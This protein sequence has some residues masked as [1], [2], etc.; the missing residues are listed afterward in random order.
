MFDAVFFDFDGVVLD[1]ANIKTEAFPKL[2]LKYGDDIAEKVRQYQLIHGG[3]PRKEKFK[4]WHSEHLGVELDEKGLDELSEQFTELVLE[5][6]MK[7]GF[8]GDVINT[9]EILKLKNIPSYVV[10][11]TP[12][13]ELRKI[14]K[15]RG[16]ENYFVELFGSDKKKY[17]IVDDLINKN[18]FRRNK[19]LFIGDA[20]T[21]LEAATKNGTKFLG[22]V[23][24]G[25]KSIF[26]EGIITSSKVDIFN[27]FKEEDLKVVALLPMKKNSER[28]INKNFK[29][30]N[31]K[32]LYWWTLT[33]IS[34]SRYVDKIII[35]TDFDELESMIDFKEFPKVSINKR[36]NSLIGDFV[37]MNKI[38]AFDIEN[39]NAECFIQTHTTNPLV[40]SETFDKAIE[41]FFVK[42]YT[43]DSIFGVTKYQSRFFG[44]S[45]EPINHKKNELLR[46]QDLPPI[47]E[48]N[49]NL[50]I[51]TKDSFSKT[52]S[53][54]GENPCL[55]EIN[56]LESI[57]IDDRE[58]FVLAELICKNLIS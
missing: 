4:V 14:V 45:G 38:I 8:V 57:D 24:K 41:T 12:T 34:K 43:S 30:F 10:S 18:E 53:R 20:L 17:E 44:E 29:N 6:I 56:K 28:V 21:D 49:S 1:S 7:A 23:P 46:T 50:Y 19:C 54:I 52:E 35:N 16:L 15:G 51:F 33:A 37:S 11:A 22:I 32:P 27:H 36:P 26:G 2:Y 31:G 58:D 48:E 25:E 40:K 42:K 9:L 47:Y 13:N 3:V 55:F 39:E 5:N